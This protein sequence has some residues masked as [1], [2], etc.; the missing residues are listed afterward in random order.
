MSGR[1]PALAAA[2][3]AAAAGSLSPA[4]EAPPNLAREASITASSEYSDQY[5]AAF[6]ADGIVPDAGG[7]KDAGFAWCVR[8]DTHRNGA[9]LLFTWARP[10]TVAEIVYYGRTAWLE[11]ENWRTCSVHAD[12][13]TNAA[14]EAKLL[15]G[16]GPQRIPLARPVTARSLKLVFRGS[17]GGLNPG[18]SEIAVYAAPPP[19][20]ALGRFVPFSI[21]GGPGASP[22]AVESP[23]LARRFREGAWGFRQLVAV[24]RRPVNPSHVYTYHQEGL[25]AGGGLY[26]L[27]P[28]APDG[29]RRALVESPEGVILDAALSFDAREVLFSWKRTMADQFQVY[30]V[31][32]DGGAP[33]QVTRDDSNNFNPCW[34]PDG[35]MAFLS[36]RKP[37]YAYCWVTSTPI[38]YRCDRDGGHL[39]RLSAN[40][41]NDFTPSVMDDGR[42]VY[43]RWEYVDRPAI[44]IQSLWTIRA[45]GTGLAG[46]FGNRVLSP[47]TFMEARQIPGTARFLCVMT[48]HNGPCRGAIGVI[49]PGLGANAQ[50]AIRN[51]TPEINI[52][53]VD[54]GNGNQVRGPYESPYPVDGAHFLCS[55]EGAIELRDLAGKERATLAQPEDGL[56]WYSAQPLCPRPVP[57]PRPGHEPP[58]G[59]AWADLLMQDVYVGL[60]PA[61]RRGEIVEIAV[62][63]EM[64]KSRRADV[65]R[66]AFGFQFPVVSCGATYAP[67]KV[68]GYARVEKDGSAHFR[69]PAGL[70]VYFMAVDRHGRA[71]QRMRSFTHLMPGERQSCIGCHSDRNSLTAAAVPRCAAAGRPAEPLREPEWGVRGF[72]YA[73]IVQPVL[74]RHCVRCHNARNHPGELDLSGDAT[75]FFNVSYENLARR[76]TGAERWEEGGH[77][78]RDMGESPY[79]SWIPTYNGMETNILEVAPRTWGSPASRLAEVVLS[80]HPGVDGI[81]RVTLDAAERRRILAWIDL[82]VPYYGTPESVRPDAPGCRRLIP[83]DLDRVLADV[84]ARRCTGC[85]E[86]GRVPRS[87]Y[88]RIVHPEDNPFLL[89]PLATEAGGTEACGRG[90]FA[91]RDDPDYRAILA[92]FDP[93]R[94]ELAAHPREDMSATPVPAAGVTRGATD[95]PSATQGNGAD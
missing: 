74:D 72:G 84:G 94:G 26:V 28:A 31:G 54:S 60:E 53:R 78:P 63:Q 45:D 3:A 14:A 64:E 1:I 20:E 58:P 13:A 35:G 69:V 76:G 83:A 77:G 68:W 88:T 85:H 38:L 48:A 90:V 21:D 89:A 67:K 9:E 56:G 44:P 43:S 23:E 70:P 59:E 62:V 73:Q 11:N 75:D 24:R 34:L 15:P 32:V 51:L 50:Q 36:D 57:A 5:R 22:A 80:G 95:K 25:Q 71:L 92:T 65:S 10:Q 6:V 47:A 19:A 7:R 37:A 42:I 93:L 16:H 46:L 18:A 17:Y 86:G 29:G 12:G 66:R 2:L 40:Y 87:F 91:D 49:D 81:P 39:V 8:G 30:R 52:G 79:T 61:V 82:N 55:R 4:A 27:D 33:Q 41:L